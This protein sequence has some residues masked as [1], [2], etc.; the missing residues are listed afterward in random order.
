MNI[1]PKSIIRAKA[2]EDIK[3]SGCGHIIQNA[4]CWQN[5]IKETLKCLELITKKSPYCE[6]FQD[7]HVS[8]I[9][10]Y[11]KFFFGECCESF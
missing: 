8:K 6:H 1:S 4:K 10:I 7:I 2:T 5:Q 11:I 9:F 3:L